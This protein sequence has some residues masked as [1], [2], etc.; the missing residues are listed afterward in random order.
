MLAAVFCGI[1]MMLG[2]TAAASAKHTTLSLNNAWSATSIN[3]KEDILYYDFTVPSDG[4]VDITMQV[5]RGAT[6][7]T[8][9]NDDLTTQ[10]EK[11]GL[12]DGS[13]ESPQTKTHMNYLAA[14]NYHIVVKDY[15]YGSGFDGAGNCR[16]KLK[17]TSAGSTEKEPNSS[18]DSAMSLKAKSLVTGTLILIDDRYD[19]YKFTLPSKD[20]IMITFT[21]YADLLEIELYDEEF[22]KIKDAE[23][24]ARGTDETPTVKKIEKT[25]EA[26]TRAGEKQQ[27]CTV[28]NTV[29]KKQS[30][31]KTKVVLNASTLPLQVKKSST[32][33]K[34]KSFTKGDSVKIW[35][36]SNASIVAVNSK[37]GKLSAKKTGTATITVTMKSGAKASCR[38]KVQKGT[39]KTT[40]LALSQKSATLKVGKTYTVKFSRQPLTANDKIVYKSS[41][42]KIATVSSAGK[43]KAKKKGTVTI[44]VC[45]SSGKK[46]S[47]RFFAGYSSFQSN[48]REKQGHYL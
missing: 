20:D 2:V 34:I 14:G 42:T 19:Y 47:I 36:S 21:S 5:F 17:F 37:N 33:L 28:C 38:V 4:R 3:V 13:A 35:K 29:L 30:I 43:V 39:V 40:K 18:F 12:Y 44:T 41:N 6:C 10:Y 31:A 48:L 9:Y 23:G 24:T 15:V 32:A 46:A 8:L 27:R 25:L 1:M 16:V 26:G 11:F 22:V 7:F 45:S